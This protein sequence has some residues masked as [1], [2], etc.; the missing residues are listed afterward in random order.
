MAKRDADD[1]PATG[2]TSAEARRD[3]AAAALD[4]AG[5]ADKLARL[6]PE[7]RAMFFEAF[8]LATRKRRLMLLGYVAALISIAVGMAI[9]FYVYATHEPGT[10]VG[11][12]MLL[13]FALAGL[14]LYGFGVAA[15][16]AGTGLE[17]LGTRRDGGGKPP[18]GS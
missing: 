8:A 16:R 12:V 14:S 17:A 18:A 6:T 2:T 9:A 10:F 4:E 13:P 15:R 7:Q 1:R 5:F 11:W 3:A